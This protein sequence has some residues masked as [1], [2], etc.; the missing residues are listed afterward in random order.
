MTITAIIE[1]L[2]SFGVEIE[3]GVK[4]ISKSKPTPESDE[5]LQKITERREEVIDHLLAGRIV[6][7]PDNTPL[8]PQFRSERMKKIAHI[9]RVCYNLL[10]KHE[11]ASTEEQFKAAADYHIGKLDASD[12]FAIN[13]NTVCYKELSRQYE[14][15]K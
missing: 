1:D 5:L 13:M 9:F 3:L 2:S 10:E 4:V 14:E 15:S 11:G 8:P 6:Q 7:L 12:Q